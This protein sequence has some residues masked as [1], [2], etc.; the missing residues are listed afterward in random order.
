MKIEIL[1]PSEKRAPVDDVHYY[2]TPEGRELLCVGDPETAHARLAEW[3]AKKVGPPPILIP[4]DLQSESDW[5]R[6]IRAAHAAD[7]EDNKMA[8]RKPVPPP[9][10]SKPPPAVLKP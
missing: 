1:L 2:R 7:L 10:V 3:N 5:N 9:A 4:G 6:A 8:Y